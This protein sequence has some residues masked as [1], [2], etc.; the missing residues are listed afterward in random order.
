MV[1]QLRKRCR[2]KNLHWKRKFQYQNV[3]SLDNLWFHQNTSNGTNQEYNFSKNRNEFS[4]TSHRSWR[5]S[6]I[7]LTDINFII[8]VVRDVLKI[9]FLK[10]ELL[11]EEKRRILKYWCK[12][13]LETGP[14]RI[15]LKCMMLRMMAQTLSLYVQEEQTHWD[16]PEWK[17]VK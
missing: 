15:K 2:C 5:T 7:S 8:F 4:W 16:R 11:W 1:N 17:F 10:I 13:W 6:I 14:I 9:L 12:T 3:F